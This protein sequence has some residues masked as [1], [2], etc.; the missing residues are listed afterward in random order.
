MVDGREGRALKAFLRSAREQSDLIRSSQQ[1]KA[2]RSNRESEAGI[3]ISSQSAGRHLG[4][5]THPRAVPIVVAVP[6][7]AVDKEVI[8]GQKQ[9]ETIRSEQK[10]IACRRRGDRRARNGKKGIEGYRRAPPVDEEV[11]E[12]LL[13]AGCERVHPV[14]CA[15]RLALRPVASSG[16][17]WQ[18]VA[19]SGSQKQSEAIRSKLHASTCDRA[20]PG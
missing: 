15:P 4:R 9:T 13:P 18:S 5:V 10:G 20:A 2:V 8:E 3:A 11:I 16:S 7:A 19:V 14:G 1:S 6:I 12:G 17:Q